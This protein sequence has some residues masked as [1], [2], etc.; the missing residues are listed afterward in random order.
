MIKRN[1]TR[2]VA[3][4]NV[5]IGSAHP[6][7]IQSMTKVPT[8]D[9]ERCLHQ[10]NLLADAGCHIVRCAV[11][12]PADTAALTKLVKKSP[13]PLIAD[14]HFSPERAIE[15]IEAGVAKIR[16]NPGNIK[17]YSDICRIID[18]A[19]SHK[20]AIRIGVNEASIRDLKKQD[21]APE[22]R[23]SLMLKEM[24]KYVAL[25]EKRRFRSLVLSAEKL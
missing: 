18:A 14:I 17:N 24:K 4:G 2:T 1:K 3:I 8:C 9:V 6:V 20:T 22:K 21:T 7:A 19:K 5:R 23:A 15:A 25:F 11:P 12:T 10:I 16:L 13:V